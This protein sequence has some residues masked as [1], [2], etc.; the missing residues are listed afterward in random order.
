MAEP[1]A[2]QPTPPNPPAAEPSHTEKIHKAQSVELERLRAQMAD[3]PDAETLAG[4]K[5]KAEK[6]DQISQQLPQ[7]QQ[8][9]QQLHQQELAQLQAQHQTAQQQLQAARLDAAGAAVFGQA[10]GRSELWGEFKGMVGSRLTAG[11]DGAPLLDGEPLGEKFQAL[12]DADPHS[13]LAAFARPRYGSG[14]GSRGSRDGRAVPGQALSL[15]DGKSALFA[16]GFG[17]GSR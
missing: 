12:V 8:A 10:G 4:L 2:P 9:L 7:W 3:L 5:A 14:S 11:P 17:G 1:T 6:F 13:I 15:R 16:Q